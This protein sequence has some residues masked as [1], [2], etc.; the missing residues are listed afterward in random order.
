MTKVDLKRAMGIIKVP[1]KGGVER[2]IDVISHF[3]PQYVILSLF[4][5]QEG[6]KPVY[7]KYRV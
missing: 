1:S 6:I 7:S 3:I 5:V 4:H 2:S